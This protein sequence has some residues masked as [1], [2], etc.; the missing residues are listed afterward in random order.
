MKFQTEGDQV[1]ELLSG[2]DSRKGREDVILA[3]DGRFDLEAAE[4]AGR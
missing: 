1:P 4:L 3:G 2:D